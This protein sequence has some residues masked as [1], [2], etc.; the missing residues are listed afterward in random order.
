[1]CEPAGVC[2][3]DGGVFKGASVRGL[4]QLNAVLPDHPYTT[5]LTRQ[6]TTM[7]DRDRLAGNM[8]GPHWAGAASWANPA[9]QGSAV[10][11]LTAVA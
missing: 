8:Y 2:G 10:D 6:A 9:S 4:G 5:Y 3:L 7:F 1:M 11:L